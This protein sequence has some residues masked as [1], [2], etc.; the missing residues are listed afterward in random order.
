M[1]DGWL[2]YAGTEVVNLER[3]MA[4]VRNGYG[5]DGATVT[6]PVEFDGLS[7]ALGD[8]PYRTPILDLAPWYDPDDPAT[9]DFA[10]VL[11]LAITG[12]DGTTRKVEVADRIG[13][14][15]VVGRP[16]RG[17]RTVAVS[18][19]LVAR[20]DEGVD[21]GRRWLTDVLAHTCAG[22]GSTGDLT[23]LVT[24]PDVTT[25]TPD[26][27]ALPVDHVI[28]PEG[29]W[30]GIG[31]VWDYNGTFHPQSAVAVPVAGSLDG[32]TP[33]V[34]VDP[35]VD[36]GSPQATVDP[37]IS[38]GTPFGFPVMHQGQSILAAPVAEAC[39]GS[40]TATWTITP[41][42]EDVSISVG[43][44]D[45]Q[46]RVL[47]QGS[48]DTILS[49]GSPAFDFTY[50]IHVS[51]W[52]QWR[53]AIWAASDSDITVELTLT[54][55]PPVSP[56]ECVNAFMRRYAGAVTVEGPTIAEN[57]SLGPCAPLLQR[58]EWTWVVPDA[59]RYGVPVRLASDVPTTTSAPAFLAPGVARLRSTPTAVATDCDSPTPV[60]PP[61]A[62]N[63]CA[64]AF[65]APPAAPVI[66]TNFP[67]V[68]TNFVRNQLALD[69]TAV[70]NRSQAAVTLTFNNGAAPKASIRVRV[71]QDPS[72]TPDEC[73]FL[74]EFW[75]DYID[76]D[77]T[78]V[79]DGVSQSVY[80]VC[81]D[82]VT[83]LDAAAVVHGPNGE[84]FEFPTLGCDLPYVVR[85]DVGTTYPSTC[86]GVYT[87]GAAQGDLTFNLD[88]TSREE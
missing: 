53:P 66:V 42:S 25:Y 32:G 9:G 4:Y 37:G 88:V 15:G 45:P 14:G 23:A 13:D 63:P 80:V 19:L 38:G 39:W 35:S 22:P 62:V 1:F 27:R 26:D 60:T 86:A 71:Y 21:A 87:S 57:L 20:S 82:D 59:Y 40:V 12:L 68:P 34:T 67:G 73:S 79:L 72:T 49:G 33:F 7:E 65:V 24:I 77:A 48:N 8:T 81:D 64:T 11:P 51:P 44:L 55:L 2:T 52:E 70:P 17:P 84:P 47:D 3:L 58:V 43:A 10:G 56:D 78:L 16:R 61:C 5:P 54:Y 28:D 74:S 76:S 85:V 36:G 41:G 18:A 75:I 31:G 83:V 6:S 29:D 50:E 30:L 69:S 46:G